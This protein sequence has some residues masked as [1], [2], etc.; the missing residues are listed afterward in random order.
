MNI[1]N[2]HEILQ[3]QIDKIYGINGKST[4]RVLIPAFLGDFR[5]VLEQSDLGVMASEE[6]MTED[7]KMHLIFKGQR[8]MSATGYDFVV[9]SCVC[10][11]EELISGEVSLFPGIM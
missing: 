10:N 3:K 8:R 6:Y 4:G 11:G 5:K 7:K 2:I 9:T 1:M